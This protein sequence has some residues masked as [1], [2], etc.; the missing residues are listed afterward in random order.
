LDSSSG[1]YKV[2]SGSVTGYIKSDYLVIGPAAEKLSTTLGEKIATVTTTTLKVREKASAD[3]AVLTLV[4]IDDDLK[5]LKVL[6]GWIKV[7]VDD[8]TTGYVSSDYVK[9]NHE[10]IVAVSIAE[11]KARI[12]AEEASSIEKAQSSESSG[13]SSGSSDNSG[14]TKS[15]S[16]SN[17]NSGSSSSSSIRDRIVSYALRF[18]GNPYVWGGTSLTNGTDCSGFTQSVMG[19]FGI[20]IPRTS[21]EQAYSGSRVS[22]DNLRPGDLVFYA[23]Y[24]SINHVAMYIGNGQVISASSPSTGIR[25]TDLYYRDP[26]KAVNYIG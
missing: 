16:V 17:S 20:Y 2:K 21:Q 14:S 19:D 8:N 7:S 22:L 9:V 26:V 13:R 3:S 15:S 24:G 18:Q 11:E 6:D 10:Y 12:A 1:W 5:V 4:P 25:I 23:K